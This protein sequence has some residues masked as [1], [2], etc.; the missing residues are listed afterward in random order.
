MNI[1]LKQLVDLYIKYG[2]K[3]GFFKAEFLLMKYLPVDNPFGVVHDV[4]VE[5]WAKLAEDLSK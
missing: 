3:H 1:T 5:N 4:P 2:K